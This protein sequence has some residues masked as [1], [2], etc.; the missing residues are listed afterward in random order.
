MPVTVTVMGILVVE[1]LVVE[2]L[3]IFNDYNVF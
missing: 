1:T 2:I 3:V